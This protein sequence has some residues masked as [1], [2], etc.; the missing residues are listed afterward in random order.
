VQGYVRGKVGS[1]PV[2][3]AALAKFR[4]VPGPILDLGCGVGILGLYLL[5]H[6]CD[7]E[8]LGIDFDPRKIGAASR[9]A[10]GVSKLSFREGDARQR[11]EFRGSVA[12]LDLLHYFSDQDQQTLLRNAADYTRPGDVVVIRECIRD[13]SWR[14]RLT[15]L[16]EAFATSTGWLRGEKLNFPTLDVIGSIFCTGGFEESIVPLWGRTPFNNYLLTFRRT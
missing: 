15:W 7:A 11:L 10:A 2:Y 6:G 14:Y 9:A 3:A 4:S 13:G 12:M 1:D 5:A 16:E 8:I